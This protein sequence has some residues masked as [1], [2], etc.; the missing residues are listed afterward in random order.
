VPEANVWKLYGKKMKSIPEAYKNGSHAEVQVHDNGLIWTESLDNPLHWMNAV[1]N[2]KAVTPRTGYQVEINALWYNALS[3]MLE[4]AKKHKDTK[5]VQD[6][7]PV[8]EK[9]QQNF[10]P[11][12]WSDVRMHLAD[13]VGP[14]GQ[15]IFYRPNQLLACAL[16]YS[17]LSDETKGRIL[18]VIEHELLTPKGLRTLSPRNPLYIGRYEGNQAERYQ[19]Q[20]QGTV[21]PWLT[22]FYIEAN[23][24]LYGA[25]F[26][27]KAKEI[28][29]NFEEDMNIHG[30][31]TISELYHGDPPHSPHGCIAQASSVAGIL[32]SM[33]LIDLY[34]L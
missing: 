17:P 13:Y 7:E 34:D 26:L 25:K 12:F 18:A 14:E 1:A 24:R 5:F 3:Y 6:W 27:P 15:N 8:R 16:P 21:Y 29:A 32:R 2:G 11:V 28:V 10:L 33:H 4:L 31:C 23:F 19:A 20:H 22:Q 30:L 9:I